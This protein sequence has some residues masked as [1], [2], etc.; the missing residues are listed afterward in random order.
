MGIV[1][2]GGQTMMIKVSQLQPGFQIHEQKDNGEV[3]RYEVVEV[4][5]VGRKFQVTFRSLLGV[6]S[7]VYPADAYLNASC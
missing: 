4:A 2:K 6:E 3:D 5:P 7:A 1:D